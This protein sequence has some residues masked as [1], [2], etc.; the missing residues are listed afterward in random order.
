LRTALLCIVLAG[1]S[2]YGVTPRVADIAEPTLPGDDE[3]GVDVEIPDNVATGGV[4]GVICATEFGGLAGAVVLVEHEWGVAQTATDDEGRFGLYGLPAG[5]HVL[6]VIGA[7]Y[8]TTMHVVVPPFDVAHVRT[9]DCGDPCDVPVPCVGLAEAM[10]RGAADITYDF[11][12]IEIR[13]T[14]DDLEICLTEWLVVISDTSQDA[15]VGQEPYVRLGPGQSHLFPYSTDVYGG[16]GDEAWWCVE[17][18]QRTLA[19][20]AY[21]YNGSLLPDLLFDYVHDRTDVNRSGLEDHAEAV[22]DGI[23]AQVNIWDT[24]IANPVVLV[25]R[26]QSLIRLSESKPDKR[27]VVQVRNLGQRRG[28]TR[29]VEVVPPGFAVSNPQPPAQLA[30]LPDGSTELT[31][32]VELQGAVQTQDEPTDYQQVELSYTLGRGDSDCDGRCEGSGLVADWRDTATRP[33]QSFSE[34]LIIEVCP[35][36]DLD[37]RD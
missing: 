6:V 5:E 26:E 17:R 20:A 34:P 11:G 14:S 3:G 13:N 15:A 21:E 18:T 1:C 25:G 10:D 32:Q 9:E 27:V 33:W 35:P 8:R 22:E 28:S 19:G 4:E 31:W 36:A 2:D 29:V 23:Q 7:E 30:T 24:E 12:N 16:M 37:V